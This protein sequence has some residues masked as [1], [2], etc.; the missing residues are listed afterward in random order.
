M[1]TNDEDAE[2]G[3]EGVAEAEYN[4]I[5]QERRSDTKVCYNF[6]LFITNLNQIQYRKHAHRGHDPRTE[7]I[8]TIFTKET[9]HLMPD[10][11]T[12]NGHWCEILLC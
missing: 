6:D 1:D 9:H 8:R 12:A 2:T 5:Q 10:G 11:T 4:E 3:V 7:D